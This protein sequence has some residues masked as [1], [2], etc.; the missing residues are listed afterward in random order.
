MARD[1][2]LCLSVPD[3]GQCFAHTVINSHRIEIFSAEMKKLGLL[4]RNN[5]PQACPDW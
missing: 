5:M 2:S 4:E 3:T 1:N